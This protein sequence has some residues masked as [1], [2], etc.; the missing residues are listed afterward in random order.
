MK[1]ISKSFLLSS[2][3]S[4]VLPQT[5]FASLSSAYASLVDTSQNQAFE[6]KPAQ[7]LKLAAVHFITN[8]GGVRFGGNNPGN[9]EFLPGDLCKN[10]GYRYEGCPAGYVPGEACPHDSS[11]VKEC[12]NPDIWCRDNDYNV[13]SCTLPKYLSDQCPYSDT[14]Y[15][16]CEEDNARA[17]QEAGYVA[18]CE[19]GKVKDKACP[20][21]ES[22]GTC[23]CNP[24]PGFDY[25]AAEASAQG[26]VP[27]EV[28]NSCGTT[29]YKRSEALCDGFKTCDCGGATGAQTCWSG[30]TK[31][32]DT[33]KECCDTSVYKYDTANCTGD[34][35]LAGNSCGGKYDT[36][37][38]PGLI[39]YSDRTTSRQYLPEK[40]AIGVV[41]DEEKK[42]AAAINNFG[43]HKDYN[44]KDVDNCVIE[45][46]SLYQNCFYFY[47]AAAVSWISSW[48]E[49]KVDIP[50]LQNCSECNPDCLP[51]GKTNTAK[52]TTYSQRTGNII[53]PVQYV[54]N[55]QPLNGCPSGS[56][57]GK[58][59]WFLPSIQQLNTFSHNKEII[60]NTI[61]S[62]PYAEPIVFD[63]Y[64]SIYNSSNE[65]TQDN[66][67]QDYFC[68]YNLENKSFGITS[69]IAGGFSLPLIEY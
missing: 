66:N 54:N 52:I 22:Y 67:S 9:Q 8:D 6:S 49:K 20:Y 24:C 25:T 12:I 48:N 11:F 34:Y 2:V 65:V 10:S 47:S 41:I 23:I 46:K 14:L 56:W 32:F 18:E 51:D 64:K 31:K 17:C 4:L 63:D 21:D 27:G 40:T 19:P 37:I 1:I 68:T 69:K 29:K 3:V 50:D 44:Q 36:C 61:K 28:C 43:F 7:S 57:C 38:K 39:L 55:Y 13:T 62:I 16:S 35:Q 42:I 26:Y 45:E 30:T 33:C 59:N 58:G 15:K 60:K 5:S 53:L